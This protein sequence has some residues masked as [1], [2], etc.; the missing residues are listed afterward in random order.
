MLCFMQPSSIGR[1]HL[2][3]LVTHLA[4]M[5][6]FDCYVRRCVMYILISYAEASTAIFWDAKL[7]I[8]ILAMKIFQNSTLEYLGVHLSHLFSLL[9]QSVMSFFRLCA[10]LEATLGHFHLDVHTQ[11]LHS[12]SYLLLPNSMAIGRN[13]CIKLA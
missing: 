1:C 3:Q 4:Y 6:H 5:K 7:D 11:P 8:W 10:A 9:K 2:S 12:T 13:Q